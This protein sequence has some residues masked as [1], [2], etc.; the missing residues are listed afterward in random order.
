MRLQVR[1]TLPHPWFRGCV[2][3][4]QARRL[5][6]L[7]GELSRIVRQGGGASGSAL[8]ELDDA[9]F[10]LYGLDADQRALVG[11][12]VRST[13]DLQRRAEQSH[14]VQPSD[15]EVLAAYAESFTG[16][17]NQFLSLRNQ[18]K[19]VAEILGVPASSPLRAV[20]F[21]IVDRL[22]SEPPL[23]TIPLPGLDAL[24][25]RLA[26]LLPHSRKDVLHVRRHLRVYGCGELYIVKPAQRRY[27]TRSAGLHDA[28]AVMAE[29]L[30]T[31]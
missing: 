27:W 24:F 23:R 19:A 2:G 3:R 30:R 1:A 7:V 9:V 22:A 4:L 26:E 8:S 16:A 28:D 14:E 25:Q 29:H 31:L 13:I 21:R 11:D 15:H 10:D 5:H 18:S 6:R 17:S 20:K 12:M